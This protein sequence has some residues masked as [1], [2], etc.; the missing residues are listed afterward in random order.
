MANNGPLAKS[1]FCA[2]KFLGLIC[3]CF[4]CISV[5]FALQQQSWIVV[6][7][8]IW[9]A[10]HKMFTT[11][12]FIE[13]V[14]WIWSVILE[15]PVIL[16]LST[17]KNTKNKKKFKNTFKIFEREKKLNS[18]ISTVVVWKGLRFS[19]HLLHNLDCYVNTYIYSQN[20]RKNTYLPFIISKMNFLINFWQNTNYLFLQN[21]KPDIF[22]CCPK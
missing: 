4:L 10:K 3:L 2:K 20:L 22:Q 19:K 16:R 21:L 17:G 12:S 18:Q 15:K 9:P 7:E 1:C 6:T 14:C 5:F 8:T 13:K 11:C